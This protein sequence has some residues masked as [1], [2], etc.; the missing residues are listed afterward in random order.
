MSYSGYPIGL[1]GQL[2][3]A[4]QSGVLQAA[5]AAAPAPQQPQ[6]PPPSQQPAASVPAQQPQGPSKWQ[7]GLGLFGSTL[8]DVGANLSGHPDAANNVAEYVQ[9]MR[10][11]QM[12]QQLGAAFQSNDPDVRRQA[13]ISYAAM[14]GDPSQLMALTSPKVEHVGN[15]LVASDPFTPDTVRTIY[16]GTPPPPKGYVANADGSL[17]F[18]P[19]G[20]GDPKQRALERQPPPGYRFAPDGQTLVAIPGG[21]ADPRVA[22]NLSAARRKPDAAA[23]STGVMPW[24]LYGGK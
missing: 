23:S 11:M 17:S 6:V 21:P 14:G 7:T 2:G 12:R 13:A 15:N 3:Q 24:Q 9:M 18:I 10:Q 20:P 8:K 4:V 1:L 5:P 16:K 19:G 22:G